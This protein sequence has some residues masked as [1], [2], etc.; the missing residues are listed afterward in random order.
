MYVDVEVSGNYNHPFKM[1]QKT[2]IV[3]G[4]N[5]GIGKEVVKGLAKTGAKIIMACRNQ[6]TGRNARDEIIE[7]TGNNSVILKKIDL[8]SFQSIREFADDINNTEKKIDVLIHNAAVWLSRNL[9]NSDGI[10][11][12]IATNQLGPFLLTQLLL[13]LLKKSAPCRIIVVSS[14]SHFL[15][16]L[17]FDQL[18]NYIPSRLPNFNY[19]NSKFANICFA[20]ELARRLKNNKITVNS[21]HPGLIK[22]NIWDNIPLP[23]S[24]LVTLLNKMVFKNAEQGAQT[25]VYLATSDDVQDISGKYFVNCRKSYMSKRTRNE[26]YNQRLWKLFEKNLGLKSEIEEKVLEERNVAPELWRDRGRWKQAL[27][28]RRRDRRC[29]W[30]RGRISDNYNHQF[31]MEQKTIIVTGGNAGIGKEVVKGL[32][33]TGATII[34]ACRNQETGRNARDETIEATGNNSVILKNIDL[35]SFESIR[36]FADDINNTENK[37]DVLIHNAGMDI[38]GYD[39]N[40]L[41]IY[42]FLVVMGFG[43]M[44][45][46]TAIKL[47]A[48]ITCGYCSSYAKMNGKTVI[49]TG[50]TSGIGK[51]TALELAKRGA[52]VIL[53][54]R[55]VQKA[56]ET[57]DYIIKVARNPS[58]IVKQLDL[59]SQKSIREFAADIN[60]T[61]PKLHVLIHNAGTAETKIKVTEDGLETTMATNHFGPF[62]LTHLLIELL[63]ESAPSRIVVVASELYRLA[64]FNVNRLNPITALLPAHNYYFS[65]YVNIYFTREL[66]R[67]LEGTNVTA[68]CL[69]PGMVDTGI[70]RNIPAPIIWPIMI[71]V[72]IFF[73]SSEQG[74]QTTIHCAVSEELENVTGKY[75]MD[76]KEWGLNNGAMNDSRAKKVWELSE[77][78]VNL[79]ETDPKI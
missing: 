42:A 72:K 43:F 16:T 57:R 3:T 74:S 55:S 59:S 24:W 78:F 35:S 1:E 6:E 9:K 65:K 2:I 52:R 48:Y 30:L 5:G 61:E 36:E 23:F 27:G 60:K 41:Y 54:C 18:D 14:V 22:T 50:A 53:A 13:D 71:V 79:E 68:N 19:F 77:T 58:V 28:T 66:S 64:F 26:N 39:V 21:V 49:V 17:N 11:L 75:F 76:C 51:E 40:P 25:I 69:H 62:L 7:A 38:L 29:N 12:T 4:G 70:W 67:R 8:S 20:N 33:K 34:M 63:K 45:V 73:K 32:A 10:D 31:K 47:F 37:L 46:M 44:S 56:N 15:G